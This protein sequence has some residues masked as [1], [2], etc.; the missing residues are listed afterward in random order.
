MGL[1][2]FGGSSAPWRIDQS[3]RVKSRLL[4]RMQH[5]IDVELRK[6]KKN[7]V[8]EHELFYCDFFDRCM[9]SAGL[10]VLIM[11]FGYYR[12]MWFLI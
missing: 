4:Q 6:A 8:A 5:H 12:S 9:D 11:P 1:A 3:L 2:R 7:F 10:A